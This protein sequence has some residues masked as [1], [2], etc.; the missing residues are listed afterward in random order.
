VVYNSIKS[1]KEEKKKI[2]NF[3]GNEEKKKQKLKQ[4]QKKEEI[5]DTNSRVPMR[6]DSQNY[7]YVYNISYLQGT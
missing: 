7:M 1:Q 6:G 3:I 4:K 5:E 2:I